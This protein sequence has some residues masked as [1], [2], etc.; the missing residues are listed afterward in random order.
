MVEWG[1]GSSIFDTEPEM[2]VCLQRSLDA[3]HREKTIIKECFVDLASFPE[4]QIIPAAALI[5]MWKELYGLDE[6]FWSI[7]NLQK[8]TIHGLANIVSRYA[9]FYVSVV[10]Y[11]FLCFCFITH[12]DLLI[13]C[14]CELMI[15][16][17]KKSLLSNLV[18]IITR[19][20]EMEEDG[21]YSDLFFTL[22]HMLRGLAIHEASEDTTEQRNSLIIDIHGDNLPSWWT[23]QKYQP[24]NA[25]LLSVSTAFSR[26]WHY[27]QL[28]KV[29]VLVLNFQ[30]EKYELPDFLDKMDKLK[31]L[32]VI[33]YGSSPAELSNFQLLGSLPNLKRIRLEGVLI[34]STTKN[35]IQLDSLKKIAFSK[36]D[37]GQAFSNSSFKFSVAFPNLVEMNVEHCHDLKELP[38]D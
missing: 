26:K 21:Y 17:W 28:P 19:K 6:E 3:L 23:E 20:E 29:E 14:C 9:G 25:R 1:R 13:I 35:P 36:C 4:D 31:V 22:H 11:F 38:A 7:A 32:I 5:D 27:M 8:L 34:T 33:N 10:L 15:C 37:L 16:M 2:I 18:V 24:K 12:F 30:T